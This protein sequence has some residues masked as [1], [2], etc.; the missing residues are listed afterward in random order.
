MYF[1]IFWQFA[2]NQATAKPNHKEMIFQYKLCKLYLTGTTQ[3]DAFVFTIW[4]V[5]I[6]IDNKEPVICIDK[7][8][9]LKE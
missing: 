9:F 4:L 2:S 1:G 7:P 5:E 6:C 3:Q 8:G